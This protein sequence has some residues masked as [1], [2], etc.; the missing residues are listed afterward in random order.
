MFIV[1]FISDKGRKFFHFF[2]QLMIEGKQSNGTLIEPPKLRDAFAM[3]NYAI[4]VCL[5][6]DSYGMRINTNSIIET[7]YKSIG[8]TQ[9]LPNKSEGGNPFKYYNGIMN[10]LNNRDL[11]CIYIHNAQHTWNKY[12]LQ[13]YKEHN[14]KLPHFIILEFFEDEANKVRDKP[15]TFKIDEA[16]Y[17][18]DSCVI[19]EATGRHFSA[20]LTCEGREYGFDGLS[21]HRLV[22]LQWKKYLNEDHSW[23][24]TGS[25]D[26][27]KTPLEWNF[28]KCYQML[29]YYRV[30]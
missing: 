11:N 4:E 2:R 21:F 28:C 17:V 25:E 12:I 8:R 19:R 26:F 24:F 5:T 10:Y 9:A 29:V 20:T 3:F 7:I 14:N 27:D 6:G 1:L 13:K 18:I 15:Q 23:N 22:P 30:T 16:K